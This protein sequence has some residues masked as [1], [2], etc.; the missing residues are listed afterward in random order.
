MKCKI[1]LLAVMLLNF[2]GALIFAQEE[3]GAHIMTVNGK[4]AVEDMGK[5]LIHEHI[6]TNL[7]VR[8]TRTNLLRMNKRSLK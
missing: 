6:V 4:L 3:K 7:G 8:N 2:G 5:T 1:G